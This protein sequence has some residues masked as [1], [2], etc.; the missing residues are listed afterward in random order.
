MLR[1]QVLPALLVT[2]AC[3]SFADMFVNGS[4]ALFSRA[5][6]AVFRPVAGLPLE[7]EHQFRAR[8]L[9]MVA[10]YVAQT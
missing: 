2:P 5:K 4:Q 3:K 1:A 10:S 9:V 7:R 6:F 8:L